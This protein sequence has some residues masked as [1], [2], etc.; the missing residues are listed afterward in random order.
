MNSEQLEVKRHQATHLCNDRTIRMKPLGVNEADMT[1][2]QELFVS[3]IRIGCCLIELNA[4]ISMQH[5]RKDNGNMLM[6][7]RFNMDHVNW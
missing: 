3:E 1:L 7:S 4:N 2:R 5:A 6:L